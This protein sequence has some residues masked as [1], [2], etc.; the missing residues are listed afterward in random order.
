MALASNFQKMTV[1]PDDP[2]LPQLR[3]SLKEEEAEVG[4]GGNEEV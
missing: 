3:A 1:L 4:C 2:K